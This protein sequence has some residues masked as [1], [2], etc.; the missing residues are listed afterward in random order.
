MNL[1]QTLDDELR[2]L[3]LNDFEKA[4]YIYL[5][6]CEIFS[7]DSRWFY[8]DILGDDEL[9]NEILNKKFDIKNIDSKL[10]ICHTICPD[11]LE[12]LIRELTDLDCRT[13]KS[14]GHSYVTIS[15]PNSVCHGQEWKLD[16]VLGDMT[17]VKL[18]IPTR[19]F[20]CGIEDYSIL[21]Q[22]ID[23]DLG[24]SSLSE[25][26]YERQAEGNS[27]T[28]SIENMAYILKHSNAKYHFHDASFLFTKI[29]NGN[30][31]SNNY[32]VYFDKDYNFHRL[33]EVPIEYSFFDLSKDDGEYK[34]KRIRADQYK[35]LTKTLYSSYE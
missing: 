28:D 16:P 8:T 32:H 17:R 35:K 14:G 1:I 9:H 30:S 2:R 31:Y 13:I 33:I 34:I 23:L 10:V 22:E 27:F 12:K 18:D 20:E 29:L 11:I 15:S 21:L 7:F 25:E 5:R 4:R 3:H 26:Y 19:D 6:C 24:Y